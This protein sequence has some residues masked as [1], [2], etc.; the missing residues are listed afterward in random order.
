M[1]DLDKSLVTTLQVSLAPVPGNGAFDDKV[2]N[3]ADMGQGLASDWRGGV[4]PQ[5]GLQGSPLICVPV[6]GNHRISHDHLP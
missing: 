6:S 5:P 4:L 1:L 3:N 2:V